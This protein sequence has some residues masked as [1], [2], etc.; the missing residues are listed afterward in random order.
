MYL[1]NRL[2]STASFKQWTI[3]VLLIVWVGLCQGCTYAGLLQHTYSKHALTPQIFHFRDGGS[4]QYFIIDKRL[5]DSG[6]SFNAV[7]P[8]E[9]YLF[10]IGGSDC[11]SMSYFLPQYFRGLEGESGGLRIF[12]LQKRFIERRT[13]GRF[14]GCS[15]EF[16]R[17]DYPERWIADQTEFIK[18]QLAGGD[19]ARV[20]RR[21][22][23][24]GISE[25]GDIIP[26]LAQR[27]KGVTHA[28]ILSNGGMDPLDAYRLQAKKHGF[29]DSLAAL[30]LLTQ[31]PPSD[32]DAK[33]HRINGRTWRYWSQLRD[34]KHTE[35][36]LALQIPILMAMG[37]VDQ[38]VPIESAWYLRDQFARHGKSNLTLLTY[39]DA[40]HALQTDDRSRLPDF[41]HQM[42]LWLESSHARK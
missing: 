30:E 29:S 26:V 41:F 19:P 40:N 42:D 25:G 27:I 28:V 3:S 6:S 33:V 32:P 39:P 36:L 23:V 37:E 20:S 21:I 15:D 35:N 18:M 9:T 14:S 31:T 13:W 4:A 17:T 5:Q 8:I 16:I 24:M 7:D 2:I 11:S 34:L 22:V 38:A 1:Q 12:V 10:V